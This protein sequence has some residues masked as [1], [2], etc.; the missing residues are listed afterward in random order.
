MSV[1]INLSIFPT[2]KGISASP[3]VARVIKMLDES[4][5]PFSL[6]SMSTNIETPEM[7]DALAIIQKAYDVLTVDCERVYAVVTLDIK[8][9]EMGRIKAKVESVNSKL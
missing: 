6:N 5:W 1:L 8:K 4:G 3:Y 9:G 2:D 7:S